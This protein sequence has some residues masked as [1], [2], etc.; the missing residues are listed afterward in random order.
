MINQ[1]QGTPWLSI[2]AM[3]WGLT[4]GAPELGINSDN[5]DLEDALRLWPIIQGFVENVEF[6]GRDYL[7]EGV[8]LLPNQ[9]VELVNKYLPNARACYLGY[10]EIDPETKFAEVMAHGGPNDWLRKEPEAKI[11]AFISSRISQ[12]RKDRETCSAIG[13]QFFDTGQ[14]RAK[15]LSNASRYLLA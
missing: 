11:R 8:C 10:P 15:V 9:I 14:N 12:S 7:I 2:D 1:R 3:R 5:D 6:D 4:K 13:L